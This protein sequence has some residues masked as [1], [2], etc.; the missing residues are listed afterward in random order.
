MAARAL[1][2]RDQLGIGA[3]ETG[4]DHHLHVGGGR[5]AGHQQADDELD[6]SMIDFLACWR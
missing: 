1:E 4:R 5:R 3:V 6:R 2:R